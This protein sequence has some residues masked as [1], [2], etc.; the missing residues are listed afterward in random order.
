M[1]VLKQ[2]LTLETKNHLDITVPQQ[3]QVNYNQ[4][5]QKAQYTNNT[6]NNNPK[7]G[8][9]QQVAHD[10]FLDELKDLWEGKIWWR[11]SRLI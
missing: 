6:Q 10:P 11:D 4:S 3:Q 2:E 5:N 9:Q 1:N 8:M 7:G